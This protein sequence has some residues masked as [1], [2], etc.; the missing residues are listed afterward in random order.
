MSTTNSINS[1][2]KRI[3]NNATIED[4]D[5][6]ALQWF[7]NLSTEEQD[8]L[9]FDNEV[10]NE[11]LRTIFKLSD[12]NNLIKFDLYE[13]FKL[14]FQ[15]YKQYY[16]GYNNFIVSTFEDEEYLIS[17]YGN[18]NFHILIK[19]KHIKDHLSN[20]YNGVE[21]QIYRAD[22]KMFEITSKY[23]VTTINQITTIFNYYAAIENYSFD[24]IEQLKIK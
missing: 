24:K 21:I 1:T 15:A 2:S 12:T 20:N 16:Y 23:I 5:S 18:Y 14:Y 13:K 6:L 17:E 7:N 11:Y 22:N 9:K 8:K 3:F 19:R 10:H 4:F